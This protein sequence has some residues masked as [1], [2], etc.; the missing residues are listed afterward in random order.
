DGR[1][2]IDSFICPS[3]VERLKPGAP[4]GEWGITV[5]YYDPSIDAWHIVF[6]GPV[7]NNL[8]V[9]TARKVDND[10]VQEGKD[11]DDSLNRWIFTEITPR[12]F[13]WRAFKSTDH[14]KTWTLVEEMFGR[15]AS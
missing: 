3:R 5:R 14:G 8:N 7:Y 11:S 10:I 6:V 1:A 2:T 9:L 15:R 4:K 13:H 12:S